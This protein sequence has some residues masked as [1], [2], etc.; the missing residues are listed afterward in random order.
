[1]CCI[2]RLSLSLTALIAAKLL[3]FLVKITIITQFERPQLYDLELFIATCGSLVELKHH[4]NS[5]CKVKTKSKN[6][7]HDTS[8]LLFRCRLLFLVKELKNL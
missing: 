5:C 2:T 4:Q 7:S 6:E 1:M 3:A 8:D